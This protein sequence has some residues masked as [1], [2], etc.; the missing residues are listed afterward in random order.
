MINGCLCHM[1]VFINILKKT[2]CQWPFHLS[3]FFF[4][5]EYLD[6]HESLSNL[7]AQ[8]H[9][10]P[11]AS[12]HYISSIHYWSIIFELTIIE[13][14]DIDGLEYHFWQDSNVGVLVPRVPS[15]DCSF[16]SLSTKCRLIPSV[17]PYNMFELFHNLKPLSP[18][19]QGATLG[20]IT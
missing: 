7:T 13:L 10:N 3:H 11:F 2:S 4:N 15:N 5:F 20:T 19:M 8:K 6:H 12:C 16:K 14:R 18:A 1:S 17:K 9:F